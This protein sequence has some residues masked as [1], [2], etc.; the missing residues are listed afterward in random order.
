[1]LQPWVRRALLR[2]RVMLRRAPAGAPFGSLR[3]RK[4]CNQTT[5]R[6]LANEH[7]VFSIL[8]SSTATG[9]LYQFATLFN[10]FCCRVIISRN[11]TLRSTRNVQVF[12][13]LHD[14][15][16]HLGVG[17]YCQPAPSNI[18]H[19]IQYT[20]AILRTEHKTAYPILDILYTKWPK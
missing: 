9:L 12:Q 1:M 5:D 6:C 20:G 13:F 15:A 17:D 14:L 2:R 4:M 11:Y 10:S 16:Y 3:R 19:V 18:V 7:R 8:H